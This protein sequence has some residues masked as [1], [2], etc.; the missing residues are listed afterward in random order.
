M[1]VQIHWQNRRD[2]N[3]T[4]YAIEVDFGTLEELRSF[5]EE[6]RKDHSPPEGYMPLIVSEDSPLFVKEAV[7]DS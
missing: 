5:W 3:D 4:I 7:H 6:Y 2:L 1:V